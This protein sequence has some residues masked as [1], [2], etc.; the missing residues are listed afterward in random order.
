MTHSQSSIRNG[1][2]C[3]CVK[4]WRCHLAEVAVCLFC[5]LVH[6]S[7]AVVQAPRWSPDIHETSWNTPLPIRGSRLKAR[8]L[9][10]KGEGPYSRPSQLPFMI[11]Y[12]VCPSL[13]DSESAGGKDTFTGPVGVK[14]HF[15]AICVPES[16]EC[17]MKYIKQSYWM[18]TEQSRRLCPEYIIYA[19]S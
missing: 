4:V 14:V 18:E 5:D 2:W 12:Q 13:L 1:S 8:L 10:V 11:I 16:E 7:L 17:I 19:S 15:T 6:P 3:W 9:H